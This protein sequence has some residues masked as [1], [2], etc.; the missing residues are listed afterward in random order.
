MLKYVSITWLTFSGKFSHCFVRLNLNGMSTWFEKFTSLMKMD[1]LFK[2]IKKQHTKNLSNFQIHRNPLTTY[3]NLNLEWMNSKEVNWWI[4]FWFHVWNRVEISSKP[5]NSSHYYLN[6]LL[7]LS[8][9]TIK[10][11]L[12]FRLGL[13]CKMSPPFPN[14]VSISFIDKFNFVGT[15]NYCIIIINC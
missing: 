15:D 7:T 4:A 5:S 13:R 8:M 2:F 9:D 12:K 1:F 3:M 6:W 14:C 11:A 10:K